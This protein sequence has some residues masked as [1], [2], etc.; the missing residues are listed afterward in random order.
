MVRSRRTTR[1]HLARLGAGALVAS[2]LVAIPARPAA[3]DVMVV[4][5][6]ADTSDAGD[7][8]TSLREAFVAASANGADDTIVLAEG[9]TY[10]LTDCAAGALVHTADQSL[11][12]EGGPGT[13]V[14]QT[15]G[16]TGIV[17]SSSIEAT[18]VL[19]LAD[20]TMRGS[21]SGGTVLDGAAVFG[22]GKVVLERVTVTQVDAG[23]GSIVASDSGSRTTITVVDS[24]IAGNGG[25]AISGTNISTTVTGSTITENT[26]DGIGLV[27]G[28]PVTVVDS[29]ITRNGDRGVSS[30]GMGDA[31]VSIVDS[32]VAD[33]GAMGVRCSGCGSLLVDGSAIERNGSGI[34]VDFDLDPPRPQPRVDITDSRIVGN[35]AGVPGAGIAINTLEEARETVPSPVTN[36][37]RTYLADNTTIAADA[38]GGGLHVS[39]GR[40]TVAGSIIHGNVAGDG[41][42]AGTARGGGI[43]VAADDDGTDRRVTIT[44]SHVWSNR[45]ASHGGGAFVDLRGPAQIGA[46]T[47]V[48]NSSGT[49]DGGGLAARVDELSLSTTTLDGNDASRGGGLAVRSGGGLPN[50]FVDATT[51]SANEAS[52]RGGGVLVEESR[53]MLTNGTVSGNRAA[54]GG[55][56]SI[57]DDELMGDQAAA[58][59]VASTVYANAADDGANVEALAGELETHAAIVAGGAGGAGCTGTVSGVGHTFTD[60]PACAQSGTDLVT[61]GNAQIGPLADNGGPT[62]THLLAA[63]SFLG[64][65][66]PAAACPV[67]VDQRGE[68]RPRGA[69][70]E[71]GSIEIE[72]PSLP[73]IEGGPG[74]DVL[75]GTAGPDVLYGFGGIDL[76]FGLAGDDE[77]DGGDGSD[78]LVGGAGV[79][80]L[81]GGPGFDVLVG[82]AADT[83]DGGDGPDLCLVGAEVRL[84]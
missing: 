7:G 9:T 20:L 74:S 32:E 12:I 48:D 8:R 39:S 57:G 75:T 36:I 44:N 26:G 47:F 64:G 30:T 68:A 43:H 83:F 3:A 4:D 5:L 33:N 69:G 10:A 56:L 66:V 14:H 52:G 29:T 73:P 72:E 62:R 51:I 34:A 81:R 84:C 53:L 67:A 1:S 78:L 76:L 28:W 49:G 60:D 19:T 35:R 42:P 25:D 58:A 41:F 45:A 55:G 79:D 11:R 82:D 61:G 6:E 16:G 18:S 38:H 71:P 21:P 23:G 65:G 59:L 15:C 31:E 22:D 77:L 24:T 27:D 54:S 63:T 13:E 50:L 80:I 37:S 70:C 2:A 46:S 17:A 40:L